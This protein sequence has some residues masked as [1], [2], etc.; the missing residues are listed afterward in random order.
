MFS[1]FA[2]HPSPE[3]D[4]EITCAIDADDVARLSTL[5]D[6]VDPNDHET[7]VAAVLSLSGP[8]TSDQAKA[9]VIAAASGFEAF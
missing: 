6:E 9:A 2:I 8:H 5:L 3:C 1:D 7:I 4:C